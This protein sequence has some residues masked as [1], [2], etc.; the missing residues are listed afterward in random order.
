MAFRGGDY[1][2]LGVERRVLVRGMGV[3]GDPLAPGEVAG[4]VPGGQR[5]A[6]N[7][8]PLPVRRRQGAG[9]ERLGHRQPVV[10][11][12][13][14]GAGRLPRLSPEV[15]LGGPG[16]HVIRHAA[17]LGHRA[18]AHVGGLSDDH[19]QQV[20]LQLRRPADLPARVHQVAG[21]PGPGVN[22]HQHRGD[23]DAGQQ[24]AELGAQRLGPGRD[25]S[26][27]SG[28]MISSPSAVSRI[29]PGP[30]PRASWVS[31][32]AR[33]A[34]SS[35]LATAKASAADAGLPARWQNSR[36]RG[37]HCCGVSRNEAGS[38]YRRDPGT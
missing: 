24:G 37:S 38:A 27:V 20:P 25:V 3:G 11:V 30:P 29:S 35:S 32:S 19:I 8:E 7:R 22:L 16:Q 2:H 36:R 23:R 33:A 12:D 13:D 21:E 26:A 31:R 18:Q 34:C 28:G 17:Q 1:D 4:Q 6:L 14:R 5:L 9:A 10:V 15:P